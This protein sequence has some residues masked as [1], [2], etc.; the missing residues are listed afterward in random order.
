[1][2]ILTVVVCV[3]TH[4]C[5]VHDL[6]RGQWGTDLAEDEEAVSSRGRNICVQVTQ[7][8]L[9]PCKHFLP[10]SRLLKAGTPRLQ[11]LGNIRINLGKMAEE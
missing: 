5:C 10:S 9:N 1:M 11:F 4:V 2:Q 7:N 3:C 6:L 8:F